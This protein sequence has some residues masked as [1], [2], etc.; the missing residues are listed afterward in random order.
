MT[1]TSR[2]L[3][4]NFDDEVRDKLKVRAD[5]SV[6][7]L[8]RI[9]RTLMRLTAHELR[10]HAEM[11]DDSSF[12]PTPVHFRPYPAAFP[13][14]RLPRR[15]EAHLYRLY[16]PLAEA[17][18]DQAKSRELPAADVRFSYEEHVRKV[19]ALEPFVGQSAGSR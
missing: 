5:A 6:T 13:H 14:L 4:E 3:L 16:H 18:I 2:K 9:E 19:S 17:L 15:P 12:R 11:V 7:S 8:S 1:L 10:G